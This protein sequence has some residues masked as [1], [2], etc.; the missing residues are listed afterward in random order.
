MDA[1]KHIIYLVN[2]D[3]KTQNNEVEDKAE[4]TFNTENT[5]TFSIFGILF[6][7]EGSC[8]MNNM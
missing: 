4:V 6:P 2:N 8:T 1:T 5:I 7:N 3:K